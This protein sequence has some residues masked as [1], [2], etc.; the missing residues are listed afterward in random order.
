MKKEKIEDFGFTFESD[1]SIMSKD[2]ISEL[3]TLKEKFYKYHKLNKA[4]LERF[5]TD[6]EKD[7]IRWPNRVEQI[8][9]L[10]SRLD[11]LFDGMPREKKEIKE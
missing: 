9:G 5:L 2:E 11:E 4:F 1:Q 3:Q 6:P 8:T 10:V 7:I